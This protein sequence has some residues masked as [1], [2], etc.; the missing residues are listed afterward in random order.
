MQVIRSATNARPGKPG[1]EVSEGNA[2][3]ARECST[4]AV[5]WPSP[6]RADTSAY[7]IERFWEYETSKWTLPLPKEVKQRGRDLGKVCLQKFF[8]LIFCS[9][10]F[11]SPQRLKQPIPPLPPHRLS[12]C[13]CERDILF[14]V[15]VCACVP[16]TV[17]VAFC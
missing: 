14:G 13:E 12:L 9:N 10:A 7:F 2:W 4:A 8:S 16:S 11:P 15:I 1:R 6:L 3:T 5:Q 17:C